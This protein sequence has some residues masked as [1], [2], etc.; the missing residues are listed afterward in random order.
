MSFMVVTTGTVVRLGVE[1]DVGGELRFP[2]VCESHVEGHNRL[3][4]RL[5]QRD[6]SLY[7]PPHVITCWSRL[8]R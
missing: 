7:I 3:K 1:A 4:S 5:K 8:Q 2:L 6:A